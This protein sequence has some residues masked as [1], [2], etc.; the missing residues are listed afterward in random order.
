MNIVILSR[1]ANLYSTDRLVEEG[2]KRG[3]KIEII[4]PLK[5]DIIIETEKPTI[6]YKDRY[7]DYV[8]AIIP[9]IGASVT[10]Y[11]CAV[12][13]QF[14]MMNVFTTASSE[15]ILRSRDKL[16]SL[17]RLSKAGIGMP[18][19]VFTNYSR[20]V[21][22]VI[23]HVG[24]VPVIIKLLEGTQGLGVV[25]AE[26]KN[27]AESVLEAFNGLEARVIVQEFI[28]EAKGADLRALVVDGQV[29]GAMKRQG[30][31]GEFR[32]NLH[33]G[34]SANIITLSD[35]ETQV[36]MKASQALKLPVCGV[37]MLQSERGPLLLEV[38]SSPGL[39]G[40]ENA[41]GKNIAKN[42]INYIEKNTN[43]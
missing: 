31:E 17:Q 1:N 3:H 43:K 6:F 9:R 2:E 37:D 20:D 7:L 13:R 21:E 33:R 15:A 38:N 12:V 23:E 41:T 27:A 30:K 22:E 18:K 26:S 35:A 4:D 32:S 25:L 34:G 42:I 14:E 8:D 16:K 10:F 19:T 36:A 39:E 29:V 24:G 5:C 11:G 40:I 28:K